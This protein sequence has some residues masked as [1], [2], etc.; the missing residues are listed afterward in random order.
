M[1][2]NP[3]LTIRGLDARAV[4]VPMRRPLATGGGTIE[5]APLVL[6]DLNTEEGITGRSYVL[7]YTPIVLKPV[8]QILSSLG[9]S[10]EG[11]SLTP[12]V[13]EQKLQQ[14]FRLLGP[15]GLTG[16]A[17]GGIDAAAWDALAKAHSLPLAR[18][19][20]GEPREIP[21]YNS[22]GLGMIGSERAADE[23]RELLAPGFAALKVRLGYPELETDLE[24]VR[25]VRN[26]VGGD[27]KLMS[28]YNQSLLVAEAK[29]RSAALDNGGLYWIEEP[30][31]ADD[32]SG[33]E[34]VRRGAKTAIQ[35]GEKLV[36]SAR[37][38][39]EHRGWRVRLRNGGCR[40]GRGGHGLAARLRARGVRG[41]SALQPPL[42]RDQRAPSGG[43]PNGPLAGVRRLGEPYLG[44]ASEN[45]GRTNLGFRG[46][47]DRH[48][49]ERGGH[50]ALLGRM[51]RAAYCVR[52]DRPTMPATHGCR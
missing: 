49:L 13:I 27:V 25:A 38:G 8:A 10:I 22:C 28:D 44:G 41:T 51:I 39:Q 20:G 31:R 36:G 11:D 9:A 43:E 50:P 5:T 48:T 34:Q 18:L 16:M 23:A 2:P 19:L 1:S 32:Y 52:S 12:L 6:I 3:E 4:D 30:V 40:E 46:P 37:H 17:M 15:Q 35:T 26:A 47:R 7:C 29:R 21:A 45:R 33:H 42:P 24:V 14:S